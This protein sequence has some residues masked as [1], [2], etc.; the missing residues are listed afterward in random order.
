MGTK[1]LKKVD[2][3]FKRVD[4]HHTQAVT[5]HA[6]ALRLIERTEILN[7]IKSTTFD[8]YFFHILWL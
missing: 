8:G 2:G 1:F 4:Y 5:Y 6:H 3:F 7:N